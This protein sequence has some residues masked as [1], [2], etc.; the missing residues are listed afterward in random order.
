MDASQ[1]LSLLSHHRNPLF[2]P[3]LIFRVLR[4]LEKEGWVAD[5]MVQFASQMA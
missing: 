4:P 2:P 5:L 1:V 3:Y